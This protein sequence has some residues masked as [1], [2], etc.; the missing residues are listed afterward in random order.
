MINLFDTTR[1]WTFPL[2]KFT[3]ENFSMAKKKPAPVTANRQDIDQILTHLEVVNT[4][5]AL[6]AKFEEL[7]TAERMLH[8][9]AQGVGA[10]TTRVEAIEATLAAEELDEDVAPVTRT[11]QQWLEGR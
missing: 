4:R 8:T 2:P 11:W 1:V 10:L 7:R 5:L 6:C 9:L 3:K